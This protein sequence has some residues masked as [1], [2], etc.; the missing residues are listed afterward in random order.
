MHPV[1]FFINSPVGEVISLSTIVVGGF[2]KY[3]EGRIMKF[4]SV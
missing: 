4:D 2:G 3:F 1:L